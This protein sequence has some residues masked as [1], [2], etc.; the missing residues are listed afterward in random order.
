LQEAPKTEDSDREFTE[1][2]I[3]EFKTRGLYEDRVG[4]VAFKKDALFS[5][6]ADLPANTPVGDYDV[7]VYL[8]QDGDL[9]GRDSARLLVDKVG[10]ERR[11]YEIAHQRPVSYGFLCVAL[12][13]LAG[14]IAALVFRT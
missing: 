3:A 9:L 5:I 11:I 10:L 12:S 8:Y 14:W 13:L 6:Q 2:L 1:A 4:A 7:A